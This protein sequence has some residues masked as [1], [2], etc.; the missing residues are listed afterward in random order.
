MIKQLYPQSIEPE[1]LKGVYLDLNLHQRAA[2]GDVF[3]YANYISSLD[4]R[5][6]LLNEE[7]GEFE[8]PKS[9]ANARDWRLYQELAGQSDVMMTSARY[10]RQLVKGRA[11]DLLPVGAGPDFEDIKVW[12]EH[13]GLKPQPDVLVL[14]SKLDVPLEALQSLANRKIIVLTSNQAKQE[15]VRLFEANGV[16]VIQAKEHVTGSFVKEQLIHLGYRSAYMIAGPKVH[17]TLL[18]D[19]CVDEL[20][21][22]SHFSLL[23]GQSFHTVLEDNMPARLLKLEALYLDEKGGQMFMRYAYQKRETPCP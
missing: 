19:D 1:P 7:T 10:F 13:Q 22:T 3:I 16:R 17:Q 4:G 5:I 9:I 2:S 8:V 6:S 12:R 23:G 14:S 11:Q 20:F 18:E 15:Q 21:L